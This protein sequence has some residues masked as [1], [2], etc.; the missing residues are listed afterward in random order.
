MPVIPESGRMR[1]EDYEFQVSLG[2]RVRLCLGKQ[3][4]QKTNN[5]KKATQFCKLLMKSNFHLLFS[6]PGLLAPP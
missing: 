4:K 3:T 2:Y 1:Q 5:N 6:Y